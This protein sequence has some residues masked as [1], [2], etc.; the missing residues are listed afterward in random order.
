MTSAVWSEPLA[1]SATGS[2]SIA[3]W[4]NLF[5]RWLR[6]TVSPAE[7][8]ELEV[9][10]ARMQL[11]GASVLDATSRDDVTERVD[12]VLA[13]PEL[14]QVLQELTP[15]ITADALASTPIS[16][17]LF[18]E[19]E[20]VLGK[21]ATAV[22]ASTVP[23][24][25]VYAGIL[26]RL[27][28]SGEMSGANPANAYEALSAS[29]VH[30]TVKRS[31]LG[32]FRSSVAMAAIGHATF[33]RRRLEP[34]L[35]LALAETY[36]DEFYWSVRLFASLPLDVAVPESVVPLHDRFDLAQLQAEVEAKEFFWDSL[37]SLTGE[38][39]VLCDVPDDDD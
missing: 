12:A 7:T 17:E 13:R 5:V 30:S 35:A 14:M 23:Q 16:A 36:R 9:L 28:A 38:E 27:L 21:G 10:Q 3:R 4:F 2:S 31:L 26:A 29:G 34:W 20:P 24:L 32:G 37:A 19:M 15:A 18:N 39:L 33:Q 11:L 25:A 6:G 22:L 8:R 1:G